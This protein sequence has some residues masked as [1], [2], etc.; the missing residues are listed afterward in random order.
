VVNHAKLVA[1]VACLVIFGAG[2]QAPPW[3]IALAVT[4]VLALLVL[5]ESVEERVR[6]VPL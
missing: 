5:F 4:A 3:A 1:G 2:A 6:A